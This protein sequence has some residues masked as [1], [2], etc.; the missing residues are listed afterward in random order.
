M[1]GIRKGYRF[2]QK[3][4]MKGQGVGLRGR[5]SPYKTLLSTPPSPGKVPITSHKFHLSFPLVEA[6]YIGYTL[7]SAKAMAL[8]SDHL[9][10]VKACRTHVMHSIVNFCVKLLELPLESLLDYRPL[11]LESWGQK[12]VLD[13]K[14][15]LV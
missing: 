4:Y 5:A 14:Q 11:G 10:N 6:C 1:E 13:R 15:F 2:C 12:A 9:L 3:W 7:Y 8:L